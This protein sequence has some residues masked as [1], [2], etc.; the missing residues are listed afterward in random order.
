L[1]EKSESYRTKKIKKKKKKA[2]LRRGF[3]AR[4][5][6]ALGESREPVRSNVGRRKVIGR[7]GPPRK[8]ELSGE[9]KEI[10]PIYTEKRGGKKTVIN[11]HFILSVSAR[12]N[13]PGVR[14]QSRIRY[15][16]VNGGISPGISLDTGPELR[17]RARKA[18]QNNK[19]EE[20]ER[21]CLHG[22]RP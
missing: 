4:R 18:N 20:K 9:P 17:K 6:V 12:S 15:S 22:L 5:P 10:R 8:A 21:K 16:K 3:R 11:R 7:W 13:S 2:E 1:S 19:E 14:K